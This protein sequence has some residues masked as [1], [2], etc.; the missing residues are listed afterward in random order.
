MGIGVVVVDF[1]GDGWLELFMWVVC[2]YFFIFIEVIYIYVD[3]YGFEGFRI[4]V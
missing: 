2:N 1:D 4:I 3:F